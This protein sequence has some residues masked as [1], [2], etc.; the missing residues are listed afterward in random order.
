MH[1]TARGRRAE[2]GVGA[3]W[4]VALVTAAA[5]TL[6]HGVAAAQS[7]SRRVQRVVDTA[8]IGEAR[9]GIYIKEV[10]A[11]AP[12]V[13]ID[14]DSGYIPASNMKLLTSGAALRVLGP[15]FVFRTEIAIA[16]EDV[17]V[18]GS[19]DPAL[20]DPEVLRNTEPRMTV[21]DF[22]DTLAGAVA[23]RRPDGCAAVV[24]DDRVF[25]REFVHPSWD[26]N[27]LNKW[28]APQV[29]GLNFHGNLLAVFASPSATG[30]GHPPS[31]STQ[32]RSAWI[33]LDNRA[34]T[35]AE[36]ANTYWASREPTANEFRVFGDVRTT[37]S[38]PLNTPTHD[39]AL[40]FGQ[41]LAERM[42]RKGVAVGQTR[43]PGYRPPAEVRAAGPGDTLP[44][45]QL[46]A[47][48]TTPLQE[49]LNRCNTDSINLYAEAL[50]K[51][52]GHE[53][54]REPGSWSNGAS[55]MR[56]V[57][58][59]ELGA[60][61]AVSTIIAD[62]SG[63]SH[64]NLVTPRTLADWVE[65]MVSDQE[66]REPFLLSL[67][68]PGRGT[69]TRRF[70]GVELNNHV[71]GKSGVLTGVRALSGV[72]IAPNG[73]EIAFSVIANDVPSSK[74]PNATRMA[75]RVVAE[76]D[77]YLAEFADATQLGG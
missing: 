46:C 52:I 39:N 76:I 50:L 62:G 59:E 9:V 10:G 40:L 42:M 32:P 74:G 48:V 19:G 18:R 61:A 47:V 30:A 12:L 29:S 21:E 24:I 69:F 37:G 54:T 58:E 70:R 51:R 44:A 14:A 20:A 73:R 72:V 63:L 68:T 13:S 41:L 49:V 38:Q 25:D 17:I 16:G 5:V 55:V 56:M 15:D 11:T 57:I 23:E 31:L 2:A 53:V 65:S 4:A 26:P 34:R 45:G 7:L 33:T 67:A 27:D 28:Y 3:R 66:L 35:V 77:A 71:A 22:L 75:D 6:C 43:T 60:D 64:S 1:A 8:D 36:G